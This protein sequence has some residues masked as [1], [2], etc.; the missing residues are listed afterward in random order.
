VF[1]TSA[2]GKGTRS[3]P[4]RP[5]YRAQPR[6]GSHLLY[7]PRGDSCDLTKEIRIVRWGGRETHNLRQSVIS[8][9]KKKGHPAPRDGGKYFGAKG[10]PLSF[11]GGGGPIKHHEE[12]VAKDFRLGRRKRRVCDAWASCPS[13]YRFGKRKKKEPVNR[14]HEKKTTSSFSSRA[15]AVGKRGGEERP[16]SLGRSSRTGCPKIKD[17]VT[18]KIV[19]RR[20]ML[21]SQQER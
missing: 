2:T 16:F 1:C 21:T 5:P 19:P 18:D 10:S 13:S 3:A 7:F 15:A 17:Q 12:S 20:N 11:F 6:R 14:S 9:K 4:P 8:R